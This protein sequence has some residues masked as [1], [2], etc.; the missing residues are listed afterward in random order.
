MIL[1][2]VI[3]TPA[4]AA[5]SNPTERPATLDCFVATL[6]AMT[7]ATRRGSR[8]RAGDTLRNCL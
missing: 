3:A 4:K 7:E 2:S 8:L 1:Q 5:G 6:L